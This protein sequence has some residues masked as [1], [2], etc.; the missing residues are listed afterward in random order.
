MNQILNCVLLIDDDEDDNFIHKM[1]IEKAGVARQVLAVESGM[2]ALAYLTTKQNGAYPQPDLIFLDINMPG[3]N[4]WEFLEA[5]RKL[6][7]F[8][9][10]RV[11]VVMLT[12][13]PDPSDKNK[14]ENLTEI[15]KFLNKPLTAEMLMNILNEF[16]PD[17]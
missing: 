7:L 3:M 8:Q 1:V 17:K 5:Y 15:R 12:T 9:Q 6:E 13:S 10:G 16:F 11:I 14:A 2:E 4:G